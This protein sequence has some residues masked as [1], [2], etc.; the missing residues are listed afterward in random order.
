MFG[1]GR[2]SIGLRRGLSSQQ[3]IDGLFEGALIALNSALILASIPATAPKSP[4][5]MRP[6]IRQCSMG[7]RGGLIGKKTCA[8][9]SL[10]DGV[11]EMAI[12]VR[13]RASREP[14]H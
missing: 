4:S 6:A 8:R 1:Y 2:S 12:V 10:V 14:Y 13:L 11:H 5:A 3:A 7:G 9:R